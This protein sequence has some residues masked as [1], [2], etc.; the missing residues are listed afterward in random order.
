VR[1]LYQDLDQ[2]VE[3]ERDWTQVR[4]RPADLS[5]LPADWVAELRSAAR[6]GIGEQILGLIDQLPP[7]HSAVARD[8]TQLVKAFRFDKLIAL[9]ETGGEDN[10]E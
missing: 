6:L 8:L 5:D 2:S 1:Y 10:D 9:T 4:L 7:G 3:Q